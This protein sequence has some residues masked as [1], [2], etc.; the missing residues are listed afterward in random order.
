MM[1]DSTP[2]V[3]LLL[4]TILTAVYA[5]LKSDN[6]GLAL[7][8]RRQAAHPLGCLGEAK[9]PHRDGQAV[10]DRSHYYP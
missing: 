2:V 4:L 5:Y 10:W 7:L 8:T 6:E 9:R 3:I 1:V